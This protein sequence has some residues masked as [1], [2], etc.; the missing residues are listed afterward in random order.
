MIY[1]FFLMGVAIIAGIAITLI[2]T[3]ELQ[4][5]LYYIMATQDELAQSLEDV[6]TQLQ[7]AIAEIIAAVAA[8]GNTTPRVDAAM[9][10]LK[11]AAQAL[12]DLNPDQPPPT[13]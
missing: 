8:A 5:S 1:I 3:N 11:N 6:N 4:N 7:K 9:A 12:D 2:K 10:A 13:P